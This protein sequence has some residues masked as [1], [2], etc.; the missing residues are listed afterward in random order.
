MSIK[1][2]ANNYYSIICRGRVQ[3]SIE[4]SYT[5]YLVEGYSYRVWS[6]IPTSDYH[7]VW[8]TKYYSEFHRSSTEAEDQTHKDTH[9]LHFGAHTWS[10][11]CTEILS[12]S[13]LGCRH[14][15]QVLHQAA[16]QRLVGTL[17][18]GGDFRGDF[19]VFLSTSSF[20]G[21][22]SHEDF[23]LS[24]FHEYFS[25]TWVPNMAHFGQNPIFCI[26]FTQLSLWGGVRAYFP[27]P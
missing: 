15:H 16:V 11:Y 18:S 3:G 10:G 2:E 14:L 13:I 19:L 8:Q 24:S 4:C 12:I 9:A 17:G 20:E 26:I 5:V 23:L 7:M 6:T 22:V 25:C 27:S 1:Q 21:E